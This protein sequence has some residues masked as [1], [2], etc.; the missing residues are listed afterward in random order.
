MVL[1]L[2]A[3]AILTVTAV[4]L[5]W[6]P[7]LSPQEVPA[8]Q[9]LAWSDGSVAIG[10]Y[11]VP[12]DAEYPEAEKNAQAE[13]AKDQE[14]KASGKPPARLAPLFFKP[15]AV[16]EADAELLTTIPGIGPAFAR[17]IIEFREQHGRINAIE[18]LDA[19]KGI[20]PAKL[21]ILKAH[22]TVD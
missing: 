4:R 1:I 7:I 11:R 10:L 5:G 14:S 9:K 21:K 2:F 19:V 17:R 8:P 15:I 6:L 12:A 16:N 3:L 20:G 13:P 18:E 22:L